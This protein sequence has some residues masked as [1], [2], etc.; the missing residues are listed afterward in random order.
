LAI[1]KEK[2]KRVLTSLFFISSLFGQLNNIL[3][4]TPS[5]ITSG[6]GN[7]NLPNNNP[8]RNL[9]GSDG[10][11]LTKVKWLRNI[12]DDMGYN[13]LTIDNRSFGLNIMSFK[14]GNQR[15]T[16]E[17]GVT[18]LI[19]EPTSTIIEVNWTPG[20][21]YYTK[22]SVSKKLENAWI[23]FEMKYIRHNLHIESAHGLVFGVGTYF[24]NVYKELDLDV[25]I[26]NFGAPMKVEIDRA[27]IPMSLEVALTYPYREFNLFG[28]TNVFKKYNTI[29]FGGTFNYKNVFF[30]KVGYY[31]DSEHRL[32]Y[33]TIGFDILYDKYIFSSSYVPYMYDMETLPLSR[34]FKLTI[35]M[36]MK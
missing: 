34:T 12:T 3:T 1:K 18:E 13:Y 10:F 31:M 33:P 5:A 22:D 35:T 26:K 32:I 8:A 4:I 28:Q 19:F 7:V 30:Q 15:Q 17:T 24:N 11:S 14:Y 21:L 29:A 36:E 9:L 2:M 6:I 16:D 27:E 23:G 20:N 25:A